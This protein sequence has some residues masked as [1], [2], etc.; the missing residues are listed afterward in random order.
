M[1]AQFL[2]EA[3]PDVLYDDALDAL[4]AMQSKIDAADLPHVFDR[5]WRGS[6]HARGAGRCRH[7]RGCYSSRP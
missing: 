1:R 3:G 6:A 4:L 5:Y 7:R 2:R